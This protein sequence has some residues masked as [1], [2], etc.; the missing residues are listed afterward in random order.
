MDSA[1]IGYTPSPKQLIFH[2]SRADEV[3]YG[4]AAGGGKSVACVMDA[5]MR[6]LETPGV[7]AYLF[8]RTYRELEDTLVPIARSMIPREVGR[9]NASSYDMRL[10]NGSVMRFRHCQNDADRFLYQGAE[11]NY[12]YIDELTHF[13]R[14]VYD[15]LKSRLRAEVSLG[16]KPYVRCASNPGGAGHAWVKQHFVDAGQPFEICGVDVKS[17]ITGKTARRTVQYIPARVCDNPH[18]GEDYVFELENKPRALRDALL[19]GLW[20]AFEGQVF[21]EWRNEHENR[22]SRVW[23]HVIAPFEV[24][25]WWTRYR[26]FDFG[27]SRPFAVQWWAVDGDGVAYLYREWYGCT[28]KPDEGLRMHPREIARNVKEA[29]RAHGESDVIGL[30]DPSIWDGSRGESIAEQMAAEGVYFVPG[31]NDRLAGKMQFHYRLAFDAEGRPKLYVFENCR[32]FI[33]TLPA[34]AYDAMRA[35]DVDTRGEDHAYD[36]ARY[37]LMDRPIKGGKK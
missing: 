29:E 11:I 5:L 22:F 34:L 13:S 4:G 12:L 17:S 7:A 26:S 14:E 30:A 20:T 35:E 28:S 36:A 23:T 24:P 25:K 19:H 31:E 3:L 33:R 16:I 37:F 2:D 32:H 18:I 9:Y 1:V 21:T 8:R 10:V 6:C 15:F 27:Y